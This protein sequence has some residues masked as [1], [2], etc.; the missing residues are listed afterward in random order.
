MMWGISI[1]S[2]I[3]SIA[4]D[5]SGNYVFTG[6]HYVDSTHIYSS[7]NTNDNTLYFG[8]SGLAV[9]YN[10][11]NSS[12]VAVGISTTT[13]KTIYTSTDT[14][15]WNGI[16]AFGVG[17]EGRAVA[18]DSS[19]N[20]WVV[21]GNNKLSDSNI[22]ILEG[23]T[24]KPYSAFDTGGHGNAVAVDISSHRWVVV[25]KDGKDASSNIYTSIITS[26]VTP[27]WVPCAAFGD[28]GF[29]NAVAVDPAS[30]KWVAVGKAGTGDKNIYTSNDGITW[31]GISAFGSGGYGKAVAFNSV[32]NSWVAVGHNSLNQ[33]NIYTSPDGATW[34]GVEAFNMGGVGNA[35]AYDPV[36]GFWIVVGLNGN[37]NSDQTIYII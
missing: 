7:K 30:N 29:G 36:A 20:K 3:E 35:V 5:T 14:I 25:G 11:A 17:G 4:F 31:T 23:T 13:D 26:S 8:G 12:W 15:T 18:V 27:T 37:V 32:A 6:D 28:D 9:A 2:K 1:Y 22:Y 19:E 24:W 16:S 21:V 10:S 33:E 34:T